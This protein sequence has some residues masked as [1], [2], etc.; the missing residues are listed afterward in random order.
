VTIPANAIVSVNPGV[1]SAGG[2]PLSLNGVILTM[3]T[4]LQTNESIS[5]PAVPAGMTMQFSSADDVAAFFGATS[6]QAQL[7]NNYF[8]GFDNSTIKPG[9]LLFRQMLIALNPLYA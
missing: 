4:R 1:L 5:V 3:S 8:L 9:T 2:S 7:A 6:T